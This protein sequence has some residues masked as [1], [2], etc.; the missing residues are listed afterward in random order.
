MTDHEPVLLVHGLATSAARTWG[1]TGWIDLLADEGRTVIAPDLPGHAGAPFDPARSGQIDDSVLGWF[2]EGPFD[3]V[4]FSLGARTLLGLAAD[5]PGRIARLV[6]A[7]V[8]ANLFRDDD[9]TPLAAAI[10]SITE[11]E[12]SGERAA[13]V[14]PIVAGLAHHFTELARASGTD[15]A[16]VAELLRGSGGRR[17]DA[18]RLS[19]IDADVLVVLGTDDFAGPAGPLVDALPSAHL[20]ELP[21]V[22]HFATPKSMR[23]LDAALRFLG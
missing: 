16:V 3:A 10:E 17:L 9:H 4:G 22:D 19:H 8:G 21:G 7:G 15:P 13:E 1:E 12:P 2:P 5:H 23:F 6:V 20:V 14:D 11:V 18:E